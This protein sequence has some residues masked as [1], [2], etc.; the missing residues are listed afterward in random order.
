M[1]KDLNGITGIVD[2]GLFAVNHA[3]VLLLGRESG[4]EL[5]KPHF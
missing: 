3:T 2:N 1:E 4:V 5:I